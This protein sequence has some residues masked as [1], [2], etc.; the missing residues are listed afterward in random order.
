[1]QLHLVLV[2]LCAACHKSRPLP[3]SDELKKMIP[4]EIRI[5][6]GNHKSQ[7]KWIENDSGFKQG[8]QSVQPGN[9][10]FFPCNMLIILHI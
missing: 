8:F 6:T 5:H 1:M 9:F 10:V 2:S 7:E 3:S 4:D